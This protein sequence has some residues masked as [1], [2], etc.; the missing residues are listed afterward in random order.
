MLSVEN[1][2][3]KLIDEELNE[4]IRG[5]LRG[6]RN[7]RKILL[8][9]SDY[10]R[11]D[12]SHRL[13]PLIYRE[14]KS[15]GMKEIC[16]LNAGG[17]HRKMK[18][19]EISL[20]LGISNEI[21]FT[22]FYNHEYNDAD[23]LVT[24]GEIPA[25]F[26]AE[27]TKGDLLQSIPITVNRLVTEDY[28]LIIVLS[29]TVPHEAAGYAGGLKAFFPG[30]SGPAV[31]D[32]FHWTAV[33]I[34][35]PEIIG[36]V[37]NPARDVINEGSRYVFQ[38]IKAPVVSF[39]MAFEER[40]SD[41]ISKGLYAGIGIDGFIAAYKEAA[42]ASS[43]LN[44]V[45]IDQPLQVAVQVI[46]ENYDEIWTAGKGSYKLQRSGVMANGGEIIIYAP[47]INCFHSKPE[48]DTAL[49]QIGYHGKGYVQRYLRSNP[50]LSKNV[51]AHVINVR[52]PGTYNSTTGKEEFAFGVTLATGI[53]E[54]VCRAVGLGYKDPNS[55]HQEDFRG[56]GKLWIQNGAKYLYDIEK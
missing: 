53:S 43:K 6:F 29:G 22:K 5:T 25:S 51:A 40:N 42:K 32:L 46:D 44:I 7:I 20:K 3:E 31:I 18:E 41:V 27:R 12:F 11:R 39:N 9:H 16:S 30:I 28:D 4:V 38:K 54:D 1:L 33:L 49:R 45:Y 15:R 50:G 8:I 23:Q 36:S 34:G 2:N 24:V 17:T 10:T 37:D 48:I 21:N 55:L 56:P 19:D 35:I 52:G 14:L 13:V 26:V 47:H